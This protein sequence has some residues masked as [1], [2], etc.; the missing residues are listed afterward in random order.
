[1]E[2]LEILEASGECPGEVKQFRSKLRFAETGEALTILKARIIPHLS[3]ETYAELLAA[4]GAG[5][6]ASFSDL[7]E[8]KHIQDIDDRPI[9]HVAVGAWQHPTDTMKRA[10]IGFHGDGHLLT[11]APTGAGKSQRQILPNALLYKGPM[12]ILDPKG[13]IYEETAWHR[14]WM[15]PVF[16][17]APFDD[18]SDHFNPL[19]MVS[20]WDDARVLADLLMVTKPQNDPFWDNSARDLIRGLIMYVIKTR[21]RE[22]ANMREVLRALSPSIEEFDEMCDAMRA[23]GDES[24]LE[25]ANNLSQMSEKMRASVYQ[26]ARSQLDVWRSEAIERVT[27]KTT[28]EWSPQGIPSSAYLEELADANGTQT[29]G[30]V[31][32]EHGLKRGMAASVYV[33][34]PPDKIASYRSVLRVIL[35]QH[36]NGA[37]EARIGQENPRPKRPYLFIFDEL[38]QLGYM[39]LVENAVAIARSSNIRLWMFV[40]DLAQLQATYPR[41]ESIIANCKVQA[42]FKPGDLGTAEYLSRRLGRRKDILGSDRELAA[43]QELMGKAFDEKMVILFQG[44]KPVKADLPFAFFENPQIQEFIRRGKKGMYGVPTRERGEEN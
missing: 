43:P 12:V 7:A 6:W 33:V 23:A 30:P 1:M 37:I 17:F 34:I 15:G 35:G 40:Q 20:N 10:D 29:L 38:P 18:D 8:D 36:L 26:V 5:S 39:E 44:E 21:P 31:F 25:L 42:F 4:G 24:L 16:K 41:W 32:G 11:V 3:K 2:A 22:E 28:E 14:S 13:E 9:D 19:D 27:S